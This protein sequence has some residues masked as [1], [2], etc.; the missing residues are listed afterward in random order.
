MSK[1]TEVSILWQPCWELLYF[2]VRGYFRR[3]KDSLTRVS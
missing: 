2:R 1:T 3:K